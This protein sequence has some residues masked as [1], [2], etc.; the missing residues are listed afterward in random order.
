MND[1][2]GPSAPISPEARERAVDALTSGYAAD[3]ISETELEERLDRLYRATTLAELEALTANLPAVREAD[4]SEPTAVASQRPAG[5]SLAPAPRRIRA[6]L[7][8][9]E[10]VVA[11]PVPRRMSVKTLMGYVELDMRR[12]DFEP[13][14]TV[15]RVSSLMGY[16]RILLPADVRIESDGRALLGYFSFKGGQG[17]GAPDSERVVRITGRA[18]MGYAEC[19]A[20]PKKT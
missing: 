11:G 12:A 3:H 2:A 1:P 6:I 17:S 5:T 8:G 13:G 9:H 18:V 16:V 14:V 20:V 4:V 10:A 15:V 19:F 7:S